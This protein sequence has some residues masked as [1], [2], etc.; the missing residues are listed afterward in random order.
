MQGCATNNFTTMSM[1]ERHDVSQEVTQKEPAS[2]GQAE[3]TIEASV[4]T[5]KQQVLLWS[6]TTHGTLEYTLL[7]NIDGQI[8]RIR[9][10][11]T[12]EKTKSE[13]PWNPEAGEGI[14]YFFKIRARQQ[15]L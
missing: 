7:I 11:L 5:M 6:K 3:L 2:A 14:R 10:N 13:G 4:K 1:E 8:T 15:N 9:G 12:E